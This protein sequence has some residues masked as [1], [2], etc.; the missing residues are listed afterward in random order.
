MLLPVLVLVAASKPAPPKPP[1]PKPAAQKIY[2]PKVGSPERKALMEALRKV[3]RPSLRQPVVFRVDWIRSNGSVAFFEGYP[4]RPDGKK[5]DYLKT[6]YADQVRAETF[7]EQ[8]GFALWRRVKG[9]WTVDD[10]GIGDTDVPWDG[11]WRT[12][13]VPRGLFPS[14]GRE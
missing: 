14:G 4:V 3:T 7:D 2:A 6:D 8:N 12:K 1:A 13:R 11:M 5:I 10:W 9:K